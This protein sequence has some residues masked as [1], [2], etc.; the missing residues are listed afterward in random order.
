MVANLQCQPFVMAGGHPH[1]TGG[2]FLLEA[3]S[4]T[5]VVTSS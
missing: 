5:P 3:S 2:L 4:R 1:F